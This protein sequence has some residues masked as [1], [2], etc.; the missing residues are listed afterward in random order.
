M[1]AEINIPRL[2]RIAGR[3]FWRPTPAIRALGFSNVALGPDLPRA[4]AEAQ[5]LNEAV[6]RALRQQPAAPA[7]DSVAWLVRDYLTSDWFSRLAGPTK[8]GYRRTIAR[9][10]DAFGSVAV[11]SIRRQ[12][13]RRLATALHETPREAAK[14]IQVFSILLSYAVEIGLRADN[15]ALRMRLPRS[16]RRATIWT[17]GQV[18]AIRAAAIGAGRPSIALAAALAYETA[19]RPSDVLRLPWSAIAGREVTLRQSKTGRAIAV[20]L[21]PALAAE[22]AAVER[23]S[24]IIVISEE[25]GRPYAE[26]GF[27]HVFARLRDAAGL[28]SDL[29][30]RDLRRTALT[31]AGAGGATLH[32]LQALGGHST[33]TT[34]PRYVVPS[35]EAADRAA[36]KR[37]KVAKAVAKPVAKISGN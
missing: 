19:Q 5:R 15:P 32:E 22:L 16:P 24:P 17:P 11:A 7:P 28:P 3:F 34:L 35:P 37:G 36:R 2:R 25:T 14:M 10:E 12:D 30:F 33:L 9:L 13:L 6:E 8:A 18:E 4:I 21:S 27:A 1:A 23:R 26:T 20:T 29:K 31:E